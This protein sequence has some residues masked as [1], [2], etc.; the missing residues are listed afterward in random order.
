MRVCH[1]DARSPLRNVSLVSVRVLLNVLEVS[2]VKL[3]EVMMRSWQH[4]LRIS[5]ASPSSVLRLCIRAAA[6]FSPVVIVHLNLVLVELRPLIDN[7]GLPSLVVSD[8]LLLY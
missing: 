6:N 1:S 8:G 4:V 5:H 2:L 7:I 3:F